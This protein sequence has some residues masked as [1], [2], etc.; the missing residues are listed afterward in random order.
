MCSVRFVDNSSEWIDR[1]YGLVPNRG[2]PAVR[3][4]L[5]QVRALIGPNEA[6]DSNAARG[7][8]H[9][10]KHRLASADPAWPASWTAGYTRT[11]AGA[12]ESLRVQEEL[13]RHPA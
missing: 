2:C 10:N 7:S 1:T 4:A 3:G 12:F 8:V 9:A 11:G 6:K 13:V 5:S